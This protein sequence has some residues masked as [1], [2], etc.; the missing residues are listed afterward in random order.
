MCR[1]IVQRYTSDT[2]F[3]G[4]NLFVEPNPLFNSP[5]IL[6]PELLNQCMIINNIN[7][8]A[9]MELCIDSIRLSDPTLPV[10]VANVQYS[11]PEYFSIMQPQNDPY[12]IYD[13]HNYVPQQYTRAEIENTI[14]YPGDFFSITTLTIEHYDRNF[15]ENTTFERVGQFQQ[16]T[17]SP[18][19]MGEFGLSLPQI[20]GE[21]YLA[22][23]TDIAICKGWHFAYWDY[24]NG[25]TNWNYENWGQSY[26]DTVKYSFT[27]NCSVN[28]LNNEP[29]NISD[30]HI[31]PNPVSNYL[32]ISTEH[33]KENYYSIEIM[34]L[35]DKIIFTEQITNIGSEKMDINLLSL[36]QGSYYLRIKGNHLCF[37]R[38]IIKI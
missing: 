22:D 19:I 35:S 1:E 15:I 24:R 12:V 28:T 36:P 29:I 38:K 16:Q 21:K 33:L 30:I 31:Y 20:G 2:L 9:L 25:G 14:A 6:S 11:T 26:W 7:V 27:K 23:L 32:S 34:D 17:G 4:I 13:F 3:M 5:C 8:P 37:I 18:I 10:I